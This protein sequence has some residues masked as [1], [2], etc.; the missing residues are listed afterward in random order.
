MTIILARC[1]SSSETVTRRSDI[2]GWTCW[3]NSRNEADDGSGGGP[4][5]FPPARLEEALGDVFR[6][7]ML[8]HWDEW[9][10][11]LDVILTLISIPR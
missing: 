10:A 6:S 11:I 5:L 1:I 9:L 4:R 2:L 3:I 8:L 7:A